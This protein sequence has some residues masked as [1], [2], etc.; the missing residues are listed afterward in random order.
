MSW[1]RGYELPDPDDDPRS[2]GACM[3]HGNYNGRLL[4]CPACKRELAP[5]GRTNAEEEGR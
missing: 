4:R 3:K 1:L 5:T 2:A